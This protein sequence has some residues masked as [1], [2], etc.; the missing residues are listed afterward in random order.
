MPIPEDIEK[1]LSHAWHEETARNSLERWLD[2]CNKEHWESKA[3]NLEI[4]IKIFG[5]SWYFTR[6]LFVCGEN[7][8]ALIEDS[9]PALDHK[10]DFSELLEQAVSISDLEEALNKLREIKNGCMLSLLARYLKGKLQIKELEYRLTLLAEET[11]RILIELLEKQTPGGRLPIT[12]LGMGRMA[13]YEMTF[14][15]DLDLIFLYESEDQELSANI[16]RTIR[17]LMRTI[18]YPSSTGILYEVDMRLRPHGNSGPLVSTYNSFIEYHSGERDIWER[19]MMTR[20]RPVLVNSNRWD[21][22]MNE[23]NGY[24]YSVYE[25]DDVKLQIKEMRQR[26]EKELGSPKGKIDI[27]RG[28]G[29]IMDIDFISHF[30]QLVHG[31]EN[32]SLQTASTRSALVDAGRLGLIGGDIKEKLLSGYDYLKK[33]EMVLRLFD[34]KSV[35]AFVLDASDMTHL[36][37]AMGCGN[38]AELF[39]EEYL[40]MAGGI[41]EIFN[42]LFGNI[43]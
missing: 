36:S 19:Q 25:P 35:D 28:R 43:D 38:D 22:I 26:V 1:F 27:K 15:S 29:G 13:G 39:I 6:Y 42:D 5:A 33:T 3:E 41:R 8:I 24:I 30:L 9:S 10:D 21:E 12:I 7:S 32:E 34:L 23:V 31:H 2:V 16:G 18:A 11:L 37:R 14:G 20:S 40:Q 17:M 4:L